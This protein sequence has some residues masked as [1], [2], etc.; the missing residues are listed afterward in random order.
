MEKEIKT[1][2]SRE[3]GVETRGAVGGPRHMSGTNFQGDRGANRLATNN[4]REL[5]PYFIEDTVCLPGLL[6]RSAQDV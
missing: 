1:P 2:E 4:E 5:V 6:L 3:L